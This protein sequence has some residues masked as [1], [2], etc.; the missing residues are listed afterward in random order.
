MLPLLATAETFSNAR[1]TGVLMKQGLARAAVRS[2]PSK[3]FLVK[4]EEFVVLLRK[5]YLFVVLRLIENV[6]AELVDV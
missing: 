2:S 3:A 6:F 5:R 4:S 1:T